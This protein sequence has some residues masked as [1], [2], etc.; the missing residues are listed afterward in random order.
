MSPVYFSVGLSSAIWLYLIY[1]N[2]RFEPEPVRWLLFVGIAGGLLSAIP[3]AIMNSI[4]AV[5][6]GI[7]ID[8]LRGE[9][10]A[11]LL[12]ITLFSIFVGFNEEFFKAAV[13]IFILKRLKEFNEP[14]DGLIYSMTVALGF[15]A[16]ENIEYTIGGGIS[17]LIIRSFTAV[18]LH[19]G[20]ASFWGT[21][22]ARAK[23]YTGGGYIKTVFPYIIPAA[24]L[25]IVYNLYQF[26]H[27]GDPFALLFALVFSFFIIIYA[28]K[29]L[30]FFL[31]ESPFRK[32]GEC[33]VCGTLNSFWARYCKKC[34]SYLVSE[35]YTLC[36][37]CGTRNRAGSRY[38]HN[39]CEHIENS[40]GICL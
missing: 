19:I 25:H 17:V 33:P 20:L 18:P 24:I 35:Y 32:A 29:K 21:G 28:S 34:G 38:C 15:A 22:I 31:K 3:S 1:R 26:T 30:R 37:V 8:V 14:V 2:D 5:G 40:G 11:G 36:E 39:C 6:L 16:F 23:F 7:N 4:A 10:G 12:P 9:A 27:P 13:S